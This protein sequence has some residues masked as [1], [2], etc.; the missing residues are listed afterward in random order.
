LPIY[1]KGS[2]NLLDELYPDLGVRMMGDIDFLVD[3]KDFLPAAKLL[4]SIGYYS[5]YSMFGTETALKHYPRLSHKQKPADVEVHRLPVE[6]NLAEH[7]NYQIIK[8]DVKLSLSQPRYATLSDKHKVVLNF[9]HGYLGADVRKSI[10]Y[11]NV[12]DLYLLSKRVDLNVLSEAHR[13]HQAE[14]DTYFLFAFDML[15]LPNCLKIRTNAQ[16]FRLKRHYQV[17]FT[18]PFLSKIYWTLSYLRFRFSIYLTKIGIAVVNKDYRKGVIKSF[19]SR[20]WLKAH[21]GAY[22]KSFKQLSR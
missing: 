18:K 12:Y 1:L 8:P 14:M 2:G 5:T 4:E 21:L 10:S 9:Y 3:E 11:R 7:F 13:H 20:K 6:V 19:F 17:S 16:Y 22:V 15:G